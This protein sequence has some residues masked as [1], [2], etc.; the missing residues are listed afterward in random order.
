MQLLL[1]V[2]QCVE[3]IVLSIL[4]RVTLLFKL[5]TN[6]PSLEESWSCVYCTFQNKA[7]YLVCEMCEKPKMFDQSFVPPSSEVIPFTSLPS[8]NSS[9]EEVALN[10]NLKK[11]KHEEDEEK[12]NLKD[13]ISKLKEQVSSL[14]KNLSKV[15]AD[16]VTYQLEDFSFASPTKNNDT[17]PSQKKRKVFNLNLE[18]D[19]VSNHNDQHSQQQ[20]Q[21][22][23]IQ[24]NPQP[25]PQTQEE[26]E[27]DEVD[28]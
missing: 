19:K 5:P 17:S 21:Q 12:E 22:Q 18:E 7:H 23:P 8:K 27:F 1:Q 2:V 9:T 15:T 3:Q 4:K 13:Q 16:L 24:P 20:V 26:S 11:R 28:I 10:S 6:L 25:N 14:Q